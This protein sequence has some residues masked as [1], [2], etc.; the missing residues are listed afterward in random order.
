MNNLN[1]ISTTFTCQYYI[2]KNKIIIRSSSSHLE[3]YLNVV[4][5]K[6]SKLL[7]GYILNTDKTFID[8]I[9]MHSHIL[10]MINGLYDEYKSQEIENNEKNNKNECENKKTLNNNSLS[11]KTL[12]NHTSIKGYLLCLDKYDHKWIMKCKDDKENILNSE[13][14]KNF[15]INTEQKLGGYNLNNT[16]NMIVLTLNENNIK[17]LLEYGFNKIIGIFYKREKNLHIFISDDLDE[18]EKEIQKDNLMKVKA[19]YNLKYNKYT[20][21]IYNL[22]YILNLGYQIIDKN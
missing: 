4:G 8:I 21:D 13:L 6:Y 18:N 5:A 11:E 19:K 1:Q 7:D 12:D 3:D 15:E 16:H 20:V 22:E 17:I 14:S 9:G 10:K 2:D